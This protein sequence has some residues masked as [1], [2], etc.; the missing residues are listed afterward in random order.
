MWWPTESGRNAMIAILF[1]QVFLR[2]NL[3]AWTQRTVQIFSQ[4]VG[5]RT[6]TEELAQL[7]W[8]PVYVPRL[9]T[10]STKTAQPPDFSFER[11]R[12]Y[13]RP[14]QVAARAHFFITSFSVGRPPFFATRA[15]LVSCSR[16]EHSTR[17]V[18]DL[19]CFVACAVQLVTL[20]PDD[21][22][23]LGLVLASIHYERQPGWSC[24]ESRH[25]RMRITEHGHL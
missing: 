15:S 5:E 9:E 4:R 16:R 23:P 14:A 19:H 22:S 24:L 13:H 8:Q 17:S 11:S 1:S 7:G 25:T 12:R 6:S 10:S 2:F 3:R 20:P 21:Q 18:Y